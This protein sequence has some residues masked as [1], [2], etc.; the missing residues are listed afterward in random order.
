M[1]VG[2]SHKG[3]ILIVD[4]EPDIT[5]VMKRGLEAAGYAIDTFNDSEKALEHF[6]NSYYDMLIFDI[7]MPRLNGFQLYRE[8]RKKAG[9]AKVCFMT[10]FEVYREEFEKVFPDYD[11][12]CFLT[13][14]L[15]IKDL[16]KII[17]A[18]LEKK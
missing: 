17:E 3:R 14:P 4:D 11:I 10:A 5:S 16:Q 9:R 2:A 13:K 8:I 18:E 1:V 6:K 7:R 12:K 15:G